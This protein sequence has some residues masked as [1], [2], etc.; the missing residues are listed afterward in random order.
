MST[1]VALLDG[2]KRE[3]TIQVRQQGAGIYEVEI[4]GKVHR[5]DAFRHD[6]GTISLLVD[7]A[8]YSVTLDQGD[9]GV[10]VHVR[11]SV[12]GLE[13]LDE[14]RLRMRR[15]SG[16]FTVE[17]KQTLTS[18]M[19][20]KVVKVLAKVGDE[21]KEGQGLIVVEAMK[22]ENEMKS[23]KD[24]KVTEVHVVEGQAVE[25]GAKLASVE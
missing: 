2:G 24:G 14:R 1:Y 4:A 21:V 8:S 20:G 5:V 7:A 12:Y 13:I 23:P 16:K 10:K 11:N 22:M 18:P 6:Y 25:G 19:P 17:G 9:N 3:E 15:A